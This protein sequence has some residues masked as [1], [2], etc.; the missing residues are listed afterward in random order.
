MTNLSS[1]TG[2]GGG[3]SGGGGGGTYDGTFFLD[4]KGFNLQDENKYLNVTNMDSYFQTMRVRGLDDATYAY[5]GT[6]CMVQNGNGGNMQHCF[7]LFRAHQTTGAIEKVNCRV[8]HNN[9]GSTS[10]YS[11]LTKTADEWTGKY[12]YMGNIPCNGQSHNYS[13]HNCFAYDVAGNKDS[14]HNSNSS[15]APAGNDQTHNCYVEP[16]ERQIG[17]KVRQTLAAYNTSNSK[18]T[19]LEY[20]Y[21]NNST[22]VSM[23]ATHSAQVSTNLTSSNEQVAQFHQWDSSTQPYYDAFHSFEEGLYARTRAGQSWSNLGSSLG[24][25]SRWYAFSLSNGANYIGNGAQ[26]YISNSSGVL[27]AAPA[28]TNPMALVVYSWYPSAWCVGEDEWL[29]AIP[30]GNFLKFK[31][32]PN[33]GAVTTSNTLQVA[34]IMNAAWDS[35]YHYTNGLWSRFSTSSVNTGGYAAT[36]GAEN[37]NGYGYGKSKLFYVGGK[38]SPSEIRLATYDIADLVSTLAYPS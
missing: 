23:D 8:M 9:N 28:P 37:S 22:S 14:N 31:I 15:Y 12:S 16:N 26:N 20:N 27:S 1:L 25:S 7:T 29:Q 38:S 11:T 13:Y 24:R 17:G 32:N 35:Y 4:A 18:A 10:D 33:T 2:F 34:D 19:V 21:Q 5:V 30:G 3:G 6:N 36:F